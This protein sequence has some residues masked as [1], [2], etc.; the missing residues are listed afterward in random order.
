MQ[1]TRNG[2][3]KIGIFNPKNLQKINREG[4]PCIFSTRLKKNITTYLFDFFLYREL[5]EMGSINIF[6][7]NCFTEFEMFSWKTEM[8]NIIDLFHLDIKDLSKEIDE[9][10]DECIKNNRIYK[11]KNYEGN[12]LIFNKEG[13]NL[14]SLAYYDSDM[15]LIISNNDIINKNVDFHEINYME[16]DDLDDID[17][18]TENHHPHSNYNTKWESIYSNMSYVPGNIIY[19]DEKC[20]IDFSFSFH[21]V[22]KNN[23]KFY[24]H[25][26]MTNMRNAKL[27]MQIIINDEII[28][29]MNNFPS[30]KILE[31]S[32]IKKFNKLNE[33][34]ICDIKKHMFNAVKNSYLKK[35][36]SNEINFD[37]KNSI[38][39]DSS[40]TECNSLISSIKSIKS[41]NN[42]KNKDFT[43]KIR[44]KNTHLFWKAG[45][46]L[47]GGKLVR[48]ID[49]KE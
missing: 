43:I 41:L 35:S 23:Y 32:S 9:S 16:I 5:A 19:L 2:L 38:K 18:D 46:Y 14:I 8:M 36:S 20:P 49:N 24:L 26:S 15:K 27:I 10:L 21:H 37:L 7:H 11:I 31:Q 30:K 47:D 45:W 39:S 17:E 28:F 40:S 4:K 22:I 3:Q 44:F 33:V 48:I 29:E 13:I 42:I 34:Y 12:Y 25:Q 1:N 6:L